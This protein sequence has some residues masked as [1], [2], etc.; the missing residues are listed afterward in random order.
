MLEFARI[1]R[2]SGEKCYMT[3]VYGYFSN[4]QI[5]LVDLYTGSVCL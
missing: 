2:Q 5:A 4:C 3:I 1:S